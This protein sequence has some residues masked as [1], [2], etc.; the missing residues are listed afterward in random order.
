[1][2]YTQNASGEISLCVMLPYQTGFKRLVYSLFARN[3]EIS[4]GEPAMLSIQWFE[5]NSTA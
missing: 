2:C 5:L 1:M 3:L 4:R